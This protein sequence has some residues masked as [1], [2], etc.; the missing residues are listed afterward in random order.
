MSDLGLNCST[1]ERRADDATRDATDWLKCEYMLDKVGEEFDGRISTV[2]GFGLFV[3]LDDIHVEGLIH[4]TGLKDDYYHFDKMS[5]KMKGE[6]TGKTYQL[7]D[8][9]SI[10]VAAVNLD[11]RKID[12]AMQ[13]LSHPQPAGKSKNKKKNFKK[14][15]ESSAPNSSG[16]TGSG[17]NSSETNSSDVKKES[18][19]K[20]S[21]R[22]RWMN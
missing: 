16:S 10:K 18:K 13:G 14:K 19:K 8:K 9:I 3:V 5:H 15:S 1:L 2:T 6:R 21:R 20:R 12:F 17:S 4:I 7:G 22:R 11:E